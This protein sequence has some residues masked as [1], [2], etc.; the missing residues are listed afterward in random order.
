MPE[1]LTDADIAAALDDLP[2]WRHDVVASTLSRTWTFKGFFAAMQAANAIA[3]LAN[4]AGHH[5]DIAVHD[6]NQLTVTSTT[7]AADGVTN[8]DVALAHRIDEL[9][10]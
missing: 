9:V 8:A 3:Y 1:L 2:E 7:H 5:P 4:S 6:Y 10:P